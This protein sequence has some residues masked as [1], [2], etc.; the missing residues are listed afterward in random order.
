MTRT[1]WVHVKAEAAAMFDPVGLFA[2][3]YSY[4]VD[5]LYK[6]AFFGILRKI[7]NA[8]ECES[9]VLRSLQADLSRVATTDAKHVC[10]VKT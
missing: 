9:D 7:S 8:S 2:I 5:P 3:L 1:E 10:A 6:F 4:A